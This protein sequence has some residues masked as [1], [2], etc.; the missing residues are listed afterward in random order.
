MKYQFKRHLKNTSA[1]RA[2]FTFILLFLFLYCSTGAVLACS[3]V[4]PFDPSCT[5]EWGDGDLFED[6]KIKID[7]SINKG[8]IEGYT[9]DFSNYWQ[10]GGAFTTGDGYVQGIAAGSILHFSNKRMLECNFTPPSAQ[11]MEG[12]SSIT[13]TIN[14]AGSKFTGAGSDYVSSVLSQPVNYVKTYH[15]QD[16]TKGTLLYVLPS[17]GRSGTGSSGNWARDQFIHGAAKQ[18]I[19]LLLQNIKTNFGVDLALE[20]Q[21]NPTI[22]FNDF[23]ALAIDP[24][25][26]APYNFQPNELKILQAAYL[27]GVERS[28]AVSIK[29]ADGSDIQDSINAMINICDS[30]GTAVYVTGA[31]YDIQFQNDWVVG[32]LD[33]SIDMDPSE[34]P[35]S[36]TGPWNLNV[37]CNGPEKTMDQGFPARVADPND[38]AKMS[39]E[40]TYMTPGEY[41]FWVKTAAEMTVTGKWVWYE[42]DPLTGAE[43]GPF[44]IDI[45]MKVFKQGL[46]LSGGVTADVYRNDIVVNDKTPP[47]CMFWANGSD[48]LEV[49]TGNKP[50]G[51]LK[52][53]VVD[54]NPKFK[55]NLEDAY[56]SGVNPVYIFYTVMGYDYELKDDFRYPEGKCPMPVEKFYWGYSE[57]PKGA[58]DSETLYDVNGDQVSS[59]TNDAGNPAYSVVDFTVDVEDVFKETV[60][61]YHSDN[62]RAYDNPISNKHHHKWSDYRFKYFVVASDGCGNTSPPYWIDE[63]GPVTAYAKRF[64]S[65]WKEFDDTVSG[66]ITLS[67]IDNA[68]NV[69]CSTSNPF[70]DYLAGAI[71]PPSMGIQPG[72]QMLDKNPLTAVRDTEVTTGDITQ[73]LNSLWGQ[74]V[75][76]NTAGWEGRNQNLSSFTLNGTPTELPVM[77]PDPKKPSDRSF[78]DAYWNDLKSSYGFYGYMKIVDDDPPSATISIQSKATSTPWNFCWGNVLWGDYFRPASQLCLKTQS[79]VYTKTNADVHYRM[80]YDG[81]QYIAINPNVGNSELFGEEWTVEKL[82]PASPQASPLTFDELYGG[83]LSSTYTF[84]QEKISS[85]E[86]QPWFFECPGH[87][88]EGKKLSFFFPEDVRMRYTGASRDNINT[89]LTN[90]TA[91]GKSYAYGCEVP[92]TPPPPGST[93]KN[94]LYDG[95]LSAGSEKEGIS[96]YIFRNPNT[97]ESGTTADCYYELNCRDQ[98]NLEDYLKVDFKVMDRKVSIHTLESN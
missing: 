43:A 70:D 39:F 8:S 65:S 52:F 37:G 13:L 7:V 92:Q 25:T 6:E 30:S 55:Q 62:S 97:D 90:Y 78:T 89:W 51:T 26:S 35:A 15:P 31:G 72:Y 95:T 57:I 9:L 98:T 44:S 77:S 59:G 69:F 53:S 28:P 74:N 58:I 24:S 88:L 73:D 33:V 56:D 36:N 48:Q 41:N 71:I 42:T 80:R 49:K 10:N 91:G 79:T 76:S 61:W 40:Y 75:S 82:F 34:Q 86:F 18:K 54:N 45:N 32:A 94:V 93:L 47:T 87:A 19:G 29:N 67:S 4:P 50:E 2:V 46:G 23:K 11:P 27:L 20:L 64:F 16:F 84:Q 12:I 85:G 5:A 60:A 38:P 83:S 66:P 3:G 81:S 96:Y 1:G 14:A 22:N 21:N 17:C 68:M 63:N